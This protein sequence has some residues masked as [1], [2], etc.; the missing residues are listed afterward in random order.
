[1]KKNSIK[2]KTITLLIIWIILLISI[3]IVIINIENNISSK[4]ITY[5]SSEFDIENYDVTLDINKNNKVDVTENITVNIPSDNYNG[6]YKSIPKWISYYNNNL[7][8]VSKK[9]SISN[10]RVIGEKFVLNNNYNNIGLRIGSSHINTY[11]LHTYTIKYRIN[12]GKDI[13]KSFDEFIFNVFDSYDKTKINNITLTVNMP[14]EIDSS[15]ISFLKG[16]ID[17][18]DK[19]NYSV[20]DK[21]IT[22]TS[23]NYSIDDKLTI[24]LLLPNNYFVLAHSNYGYFSLLICIIIIIISIG[25]F[26]AWKRYGKDYLKRSKTVEFYPPEELDSSQIGYIYGENDIKKLTTSLIIS[27]AS[28][29]YISIEEDN[30][31]IKIINTLKDNSKLKKLSINEQIVYLELFK[32]KDINYIQE[33]NNFSSVFKKIKKSL[34]NTI[35][36]KV[37]DLES[38]KMMYIIFSLLILEIIFWT[39]SYLFIR[40]LNPTYN[41]LYYISF[42]S[43]FITG[44]F[45]IIMSRKTNYGE[46]ITARILGFRDYLETVEKDKLEK[47]VLDNPNY[48][49][50]ILPYTYVLNISNKWINDFNKKMISNI[51]L[52]YFRDSDL[53]III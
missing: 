29:N 33:D 21:T 25:S 39:I 42:I 35:D 13:N 51:N 36:K 19:I 22:A 5:I 23:N 45:S 2:Y 3:P 31:K 18:T 53:F 34:E 49:Y 30:K 1:M 7:D 14:K 16:D 46:V 20:N 47:I 11:G 24:K 52:N 26:I 6:I 43:I 9:L 44:L 37:N 10:I 41:I 48:F 8:K 12:M 32:D 50:D 4:N 28:K 40:D 15:N 17:I 38:R 27:L